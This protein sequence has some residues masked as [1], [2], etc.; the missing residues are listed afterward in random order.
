MTRVLAVAV[1]FV[2]LGGS[3]ASASP[4][5]Y[6]RQLCEADPA[7]TCSVEASVA[8]G[9][10]A[11]SGSARSRV[12]PFVPVASAM[13]SATA[14]EYW[15]T[16]AERGSRFLMRVD[17]EHYTYERLDALGAPTSPE[18]GEGVAIRL[19][20]LTSGGIFDEKLVALGQAGEVTLLTP[21]DTQGQVS[22]FEV[23]LHLFAEINAFEPPARLVRAGAR[24]V[25]EVPE[26]I[27]CA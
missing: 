10:L 25:Y 23:S 14:Q 13:V 19:R 8:E 22:G 2:S 5:G 24:A 16:G 1:A 7:S 18:Q 4:Q 12:S 26:V 21:C 11:V 20:A 27:P 9:A 17:V 15:P 3:W 6:T